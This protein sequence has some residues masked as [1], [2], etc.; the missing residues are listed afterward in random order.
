VFVFMISGAKVRAP[1]A[2]LGMIERVG[3]PSG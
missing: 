1:A 2:A 3:R